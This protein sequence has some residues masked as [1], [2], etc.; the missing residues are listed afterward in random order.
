[1]WR[2]CEKEGEGEEGMMM[3]MMMVMQLLTPQLLAQIL[4]WYVQATKLY[5]K[6]VATVWP[7]GSSW[8][9]HSVVVVVSFF[10]FFLKEFWFLAKM[11]IIH[12][13]MQK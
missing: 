1:V 4:W 11:A 2:G 10:F 5:H 13:K 6:I 7:L 9:C 8:V 12:R 3:M